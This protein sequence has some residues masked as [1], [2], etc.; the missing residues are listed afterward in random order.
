MPRLD[1]TTVTHLFPRE[2]NAAEP[3]IT[4]PSW[5]KPVPGCVP[6][7]GRNQGLNHA[8]GARGKDMAPMLILTVPNPDPR[9]Y[10][11]ANS[12]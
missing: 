10:R 2:N 12:R 3:H 1:L 7:V 5:K 9:R 11:N 6:G 8:R 4:V